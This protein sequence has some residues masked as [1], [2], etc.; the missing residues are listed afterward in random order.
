MGLRLR[1]KIILFSLCLTIFTH[2]LALSN[3]ITRGD[4]V[5]AS[6]EDWASSKGLNLSAN[7]NERRTYPGCKQALSIEPRYIGDYNTLKISCDDFGA[8]WDINISTRKLLKN[9]NSSNTNMAIVIA[10]TAL[11]KGTVISDKD[12]EL[13]IGANQNNGQY[14]SELDDVV[15]RRARRAINAKQMIKPQYLTSVWMVEK[16]QSVILVNKSARIQV[17]AIGTA[18]EN[19]NYGDR[20]RVINN[21]SG[22]KLLGKIESEKKI[23]IIAKIN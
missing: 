2:S 10:K 16:D 8:E 9:A 1:M 18:L 22:Q 14:F 21:K 4:K 15:G 12:I 13:K 3:E 23:Q 19:G 20:I 17:E 11:P 7:I 6:V 5:I